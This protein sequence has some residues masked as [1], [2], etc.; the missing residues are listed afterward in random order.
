[1]LVSKQIDRSGLPLSAIMVYVP[2]SVGLR[3]KALSLPVKTKPLMGRLPEGYHF[4]EVRGFIYIFTPT[5]V[6]LGTNFLVQYPTSTRKGSSIQGTQGPRSIKQTR[7]SFIFVSPD[8][9]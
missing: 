5:V 9:S 4:L 1:M 8:N 2:G 6:F 7:I 3:I